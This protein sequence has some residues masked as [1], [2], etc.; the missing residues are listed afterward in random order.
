M[1][2]RWLAAKRGVVRIVTA[3]SASRRAIRL[4]TGLQ[5]VATM[6]R[7]PETGWA[8]RFSGCLNPPERY[9]V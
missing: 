6:Q 1:A 7:Q 8:N 3:M 2:R 9:A 5:C 4:P